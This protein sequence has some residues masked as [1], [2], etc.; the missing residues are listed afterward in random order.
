MVGLLWCWLCEYAELSF[1]THSFRWSIKR[2]IVLLREWSCWVQLEV[3]SHH[4]GKFAV[5]AWRFVTSLLHSTT[6][7]NN[8]G[9]NPDKC[10]HFDVAGWLQRGERL[11]FYGQEAILLHLIARSN[12]VNEHKDWGGLPKITLAMGLCSAEYR[13]STERK[14]LPFI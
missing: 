14:S 3:H 7:V 4:W 13:A 8:S 5:Y 6:C 12:M 2:R 1:R 9:D 10:M 11:H